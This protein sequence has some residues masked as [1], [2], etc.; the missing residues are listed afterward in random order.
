MTASRVK[1][2]LLSSISIGSSLPIY[3]YRL[4]SLLSVYLFLNPKPFA[5]EI[6]KP[7]SNQIKDEASK[8]E[9]LLKSYI[10]HLQVQNRMPKDESAPHRFF[11]RSR[12][13]P[14]ARS[15]INTEQYG[16]KSSLQSVGGDEKEWEEVRCPI[17]MEHPHN[18]VLLL[19]SSHEKGCHPYMCDTSQRHSNCFDLFCKSSATTPSS[20]DLTEQVPLYTAAYHGGIEEQQQNIIPRGIHGRQF[21]PKL[22]CP[23]CRGQIDG[24]IVIKPARIFMNSKPRSCSL[25]TCDFSGTY[26]ELRKHARLEHPFVRPSE[27]D[28]RRQS[29]WMSLEHERDV[30]DIIGASGLVSA[31]EWTHWMSLDGV[32]EELILGSSQL[33]SADVW[34]DWMSLDEAIEALPNALQP[35]VEDQQY[36]TLHVEVEFNP[37]FSFLRYALNETSVSGSSEASDQS[38]NWRTTTMLTTGNPPSPSV[39]SLNETS[40]SGSSEARDQSR[41]WT[42][43]ARLRVGNPPIPRVDSLNATSVS[44]SSEA[45]AQPHNERTTARMRVGALPR[46]PL[47]SRNG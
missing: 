22:S 4:I 28:S 9:T 17:C 12:A 18:A 3:I 31:E 23:L 32:I 44:G 40:V 24:S 6:P 42:T 34:N 41:N 19:C 10:T 1:G 45:S 2:V 5:A 38:F 13:S 37:S 35:E 25:E 33:E 30:Q 29:D 15:P 21:Q 11:D 7:R 36:N 39:N 43:T 20:T 47:A 8:L 46:G 16:P 27:A 14:Y 26:S